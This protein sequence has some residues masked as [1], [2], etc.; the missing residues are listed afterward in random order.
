MSDAAPPDPSAEAVAWLTRFIANPPLGPFDAEEITARVDDLSGL[1]R[2]R[3]LAPLW[4]RHLACNRG[5]IPGALSSLIFT[6]EHV[7]PESRGQPPVFDSGAADVALAGLVAHIDSRPP[8]NFRNNSPEVPLTDRQ[9][10]HM[11]LG[12]LA[13]LVLRRMVA[14]PGPEGRAALAALLAEDVIHDPVS[15]MV[16][17]HLVGDPARM[18]TTRAAVM[19][20]ADSDLARAELEAILTA[21]V[22]RWHGLLRN[23]RIGYDLTQSSDAAD[24]PADLPAWRAFAETAVADALAEVRAVQ[25]GAVPYVA[26]KLMSPDAA[27]TVGRAMRLAL[28]ENLDWG[29]SVLDELWHGAAIAPNPKAKTVPSQPLTYALAHAVI[30]E[31]RP[32]AL[33]CLERVAR[34]VRHASVTKKLEKMVKSARNALQ[35][36][37]E[38]LLE[39]ALEGGVPEDLRRYLNPALEG[40]LLRD[41]DM[42]QPA[43][44]A[45]MGQP[46]LRG[47]TE[48][49]IWDITGDGARFGGLPDLDG[50]CWRMSD[51]T[52]R[53][54]APDQKVRLWH[55]ADWPEEIRAAWRARVADGVRQP[56][57]QAFREVYPLPEADLAGRRTEG[58]AGIAIAQIPAIGVARRSGFQLGY[59]DAL[60]LALGGQRFVFHAGVRS[61]PGAG[62]EGFTGA[63]E[64]VGP[65]RSLGEVAPRVLNEA[66]RRIDLV[67]ATGAA[68]V[69]DSAAILHPDTFRPLWPGAQS[70]AMRQALLEL[71]RPKARI[72]GR[73]LMLGGGA[74][75]HLG[76]GRLDRDGTPLD[77]PKVKRGATARSDDGVMDRIWAAI[78]AHGLS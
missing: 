33:R 64:L 53:E 22:G 67:V 40:L 77:L 65:A 19:A 78:A 57:T 29:T 30:A 6:L 26:D 23:H 37:P 24:D 11:R 27:R 1:D 38:L 70:I 75:I 72:E 5:D 41:W 73:W 4:A 35:G 66:L 54:M 51:G 76:T 60:M 12:Y 13:A 56:F 10:W 34:S 7:L 44:A 17:A 16:A 42:D 69:A 71:T 68:G 28:A 21:P 14:E 2:G 49:L 55:P 45:Q 58:F 36:R 32:A 52:T 43:W 61:F 62:G 15:E 3:L 39:M 50:A 18:M 31:P 47:A 8:E 74:R 63:I 20:M 59:E 46:D 25:S 9:M 48:A